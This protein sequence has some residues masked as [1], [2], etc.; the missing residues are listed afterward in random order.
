MMQRVMRLSAIGLTAGLLAGAALIEPAEAAQ[1]GLDRW[2]LIRNNSSV[3]MM[4]FYGSNVDR[5]VWEED[6]LGL[7]VLVPGES[8]W[9][10]FDDGS[11][12]C[13]FD[14]RAVFENGAE[15]TQFGVNVCEARGITFRGNRN[16]R[17][18]Y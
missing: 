5:T 4:E 6:I 10:N 3:A 13:R 15:E 17:I 7:D 16:I 8:V 14:L 18:R 2:V 9:V 12:Y 1:D 11:G